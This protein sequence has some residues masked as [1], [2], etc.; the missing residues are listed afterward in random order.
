MLDFSG[1]T[2]IVTGAT[3]NLGAAIAETLARLGARLALA[4]M[5]EE[6]L[7]Q[8]AAR[9][10]GDPFVIAGADVRT[11]DGATHIVE[12]CHARFGRIDGLAN[13]VGTFKT[14]NVVDSTADD[15][16]SL[17]DLNA[18]SALR[19]SEAVLGRLTAQGYGRIVHVAAAAGTK[20][21]AGASVYAASKAAVMRI[22]EAISEEHK[23]SGVTA[24]CIIPGTIDTPQNRASMPDADFST[25]VHPSQIAPAVAFLLSREAGAVTGAS[26]PI[27]GRQ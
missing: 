15:W 23:A 3:G 21:F 16:S 9:I 5:R 4:D 22:T 14:A 13:T 10:A 17:M 18:L 6:P 19:I 7:Q 1:Q 11:K 8:L 25:W 27:T 20:S 26:L 24:N 2:I 12:A